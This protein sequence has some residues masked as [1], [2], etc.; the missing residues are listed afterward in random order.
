MR[1]DYLFQEQFLVVEFPREKLN[2]KECY[3]LEGF[4]VNF[5]LQELKILVEIIL[6]R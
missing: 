3:I 6:E 1:Q 2:R 5:Q 4:W